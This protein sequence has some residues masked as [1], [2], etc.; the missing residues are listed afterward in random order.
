MTSPVSHPF[1]KRTGTGTWN[2]AR[3]G[4]QSPVAKFVKGACS[5]A[6]HDL[7]T[8]D[9]A[10]ELGEWYKFK[11]CSMAPRHPSSTATSSD[12]LACLLTYL[13]SAAQLPQLASSV[14]PR[15]L[16]KL[17][18]L[19]AAFIQALSNLS[20]PVPRRRHRIWLITYLHSS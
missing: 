20:V 12:L 9:A 2:L 19:R 3:V 6:G 15:S 4:D 8:L 13:H 7:V 18:L 5:G 11:R 16:S 17:L 10:R 14:P 1:K